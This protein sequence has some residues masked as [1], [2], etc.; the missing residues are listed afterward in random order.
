MFQLFK[1]LFIILVGDLSNKFIMIPL[2]LNFCISIITG[3]ATMKQ[4]KLW[5]DHSE[6]LLYIQN[7]TNNETATI[8]N[9]PHVKKFLHAHGLKVQDLT[10]TVISTDITG[11]FREYKGG[12]SR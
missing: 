4:I 7:L 2:P 6:K 11:V 1:Q 5:F 3:V 12:V 8:S 10:D 9:A